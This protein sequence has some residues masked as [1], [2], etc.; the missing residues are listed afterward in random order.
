[1]RPAIIGLAVA[2]AIAYDLQVY[3]N[4]APPGPQR[5]L[6]SL[7]VSRL[8]CATRPFPVFAPTLSLCLR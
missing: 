3:A 1:M 4:A 6:V 5:P 2:A 7:Y 8:T